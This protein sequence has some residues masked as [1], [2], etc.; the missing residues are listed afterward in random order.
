MAHTL[1]SRPGARHNRGIARRSCFVFQ[2]HPFRAGEF[3]LLPICKSLPPKFGFGP[4]REIS[5]MPHLFT[6]RWPLFARLE[7]AFLFSVALLLAY[8]F[9]PVRAI[10]ENGFVPELSPLTQTL[11]L[12]RGAIVWMSVAIVA[13]L[14]YLAV[15]VAA[16]RLMTVRKGYA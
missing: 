11:G 10:A 9:A 13:L 14:P 12:P 3:H 1:G 4:P 8:Q 2:A 6:V 16:D 7:A 15:L 5:Q